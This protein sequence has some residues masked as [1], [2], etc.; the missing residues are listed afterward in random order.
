MSEQIGDEKPSKR[1]KKKPAQKAAQEKFQAV[2]ETTNL[3]RLRERPDGD[4]I[5][6]AF[7]KESI[8]ELPRQEYLILGFDT[9]YQAVKEKN[10][11]DD[12]EEGRAKYEVLSYQFY[13]MN[14]TGEEWS[15]ITIPKFGQRMSLTDF[16]VYAI[17]KGA[18]LGYVIPKTIVLVGHY[19]R[20]DLPAFDDRKQLW[21]RL[22]NVRNS[23]V[24]LG[25]PVHIRVQFSELE[26]DTID[27]SVYVRDTILH[28]P[29]GKKSLAGLGGLIGCEKIKLCDD[30]NV[31]RLLKSRMSAVRADD[32]TLFKEYAIAD[33]EISARY[34]KQLAERVRSILPRMFAPTALSNIGQKLLVEEW[35]AKATGNKKAYALE[36]VGREAHSELL[37]DEKR[38]CFRTQKSTP[39]IEE[40]NWHIDFVSECYHGGRNE[41]MQFGPSA[42]GAWTDYDLTGA[43]PTAMAMIG[44][45]RWREIRIV[46]DLDELLQ[47]DF[48]FACVEFKAPA[49]TRY[50]I[51]PVRTQNGI[52]FPMSGRSYCATP[53]I[54]LAKRLG[55]DIE[56]KHAVVIPQNRDERPF[57][58]FIKEAIA[59]RNSA[60]EKIDQAFWKEVA[61]SCYGKTAQGLRDKRVF[62][63]RLR[64]NER[65]QPSEITNP[66]YAAYITSMVRA[67]VG[68]IM[69]AIPASKEVFSVT[70][71]GF[72]TNATEGEMEIAGSGELCQRYRDAREELTGIAEVLSEKHAVRR[73]LGWRTRGQATL[74]PGE[75]EK[76]EKHIVLA[77][78]GIKSPVEATEL[79]EQNTHILQTFFGREPKN[80]IELDVHT[81]V[82][83]MI[84]YD[85]DLVSKE[86][87][88]N[89]RM[90]YDMKRRPKALAM[91][92]CND[93]NHPRRTI[94]HL[95]FITEPWRSVDEFMLVRKFWDDYW[96]KC[97]R[98]FKT[99]DDYADFAQLFD[100]LKSLSPRD[101]KYMRKDKGS[102][103]R[104]K[105]SLC[106]AFKQGEAGLSAYREMR[107]ADFAANLN[108]SGMLESGV[109]VKVADVEN[110]KRFAFKP[111]ATPSDP[112]ALSVLSRLSERLPGLVISEIVAPYVDD[113]INL[114]RALKEVYSSDNQAG[115]REP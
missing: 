72:L 53:E 94:E 78:A 100:M 114:S 62:G 20:A 73:V 32:W 81:S 108:E 33:A 95:A 80:P 42:E 10:T 65:V 14:P 21:M 22:N 25:L 97:P 77:K 110:G 55:Y 59:K 105:Q 87:K 45:P 74:V 29:A 90:E 35:T 83:D 75:N 71:D 113:G 104:L 17:S 79:E 107:A 91:S 6:F 8:A 11:Q 54:S 109:M 49:G 63:L 39:Y 93:P 106:R 56:V 51:F 76:D 36:M 61:N 69:N 44:K 30:P 85:A 38:Q 102:L 99:I 68:E 15:G 37:Y 4:L 111:H 2:L 9:E 24:S 19:N 86:L 40:I 82:R 7:L 50:P 13:A 43:Y 1:R 52:I 84:F 112:L 3:V 26:D 67:V 92:R 27:L 23:L 48:G 98:C 64:R 115:C 16:I 5:D 12:V 103:Q 46:S 57:F 96:A 31:E 58:D 18:E 66:F 28:A 88:R 101:Q 41:Q 47:S 70:T 60:S 89:V 34:Y